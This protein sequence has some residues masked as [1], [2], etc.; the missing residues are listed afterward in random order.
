MIVVFGKWKIETK[1]Y[2]SLP[3]LCCQYSGT[4]TVINSSSIVQT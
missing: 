2:G 4:V 3:I 1:K